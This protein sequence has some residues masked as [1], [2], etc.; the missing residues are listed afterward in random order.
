MPERLFHPDSVTWRVNQEPALLLGGA[1]A[2]LMQLA[3][4]SVAAGVAEH[5]DFRQRPLERLVRTLE[6]TLALTFGTRQQSLAAA[7][8]IN[9]VHQRVRGSGYSATDPTLLL[10][11]HAT[12]IDSALITYAAFVA[13]LPAEER[14]TY[15]Q[16]AKLLGGLLGLANSRYPARLDEF[17]AYMA[18]MVASD[19]LAVDDRARELAAAVLRPPLRRVPRSAFRP[20]EA[21]TAGL[22][23]ERLRHA[24]G[25]RW[26][27][28]ERLGY[29]TARA[30]LPRALGLLPRRFREVPPAR[31]GR[32]T[33]SSLKSLY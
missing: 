3:H 5:S 31:V 22:L 16:E 26:G 32:L 14:E 17:E 2:L 6:L 23:P 27:R 11:V 19:E 9:A 15:Y 25:L 12:L 18:D 30:G 1:R 4:P 10:W 13:P 21:I 7:R 20:V 8:Q 24:Y 28:L 33:S 29:R